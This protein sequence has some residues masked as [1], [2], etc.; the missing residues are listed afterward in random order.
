VKHARVVT[1]AHEAW[2]EWVRRKGV[3]KSMK[4]WNEPMVDH[5]SAGIFLSLFEFMLARGLIF[6]WSE[7]DGMS[8]R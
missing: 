7:G 1:D 4:I 3:T 5:I 2:M 8:A 6:L